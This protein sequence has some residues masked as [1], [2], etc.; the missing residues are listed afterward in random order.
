MLDECDKLLD[1]TDMRAKVQKIFMSGN[2]ENRQVM[3]F[4]ATMSDELKGVCKMYMKQPFELYIE[5]DSKLTLHGLKQ[6]Y[7]KLEDNQKVKKLFTLLDN[8]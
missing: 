2:A 1:Q 3:M 8:L 5:T 6:Y 7:C 4:S